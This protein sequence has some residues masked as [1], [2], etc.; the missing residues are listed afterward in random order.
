MT[1]T[2]MRVI[3]TEYQGVKF[4][5]RLEARWAVL[6]DMLNVP[7][8]YEPE[9]FTWPSGEVMDGWGD[10]VD[11]AW[12]PRVTEG[13]S[14]TP[15]FWLPSL[16]T[17]FEV[18]GIYTER[19]QGLHQEFASVSKQ[20]HITAEGD[21]AREVHG[22]GVSMVLNGGEDFGYAWCICPW[23][24]KPGIEFGGRGAR[25]CGYRAH[26]ETETA[27]MKHPG[28]VSHRADDRCETGDAP[29]IIEAFNVARA[30][31]F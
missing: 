16:G 4:R 18:K 9:A 14:Y 13:G 8:Q 5:S 12:Q 11:G 25:V 19:E 7:W 22:E 20:R 1:A 3:P 28:F 27:A 6:F 24:K 30:A 29:V 2:A 15:D 26:Y 31:R 10:W 21:C 23:C 17:W